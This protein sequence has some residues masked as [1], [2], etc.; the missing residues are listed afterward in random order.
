MAAEMPPCSNYGVAHVFVFGGVSMRPVSI[1]DRLRGSSI[2]GVAVGS[3]GC[4]QLDSGSH[5]NPD[6]ADDAELHARGV[7]SRS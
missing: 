2:V 4:E 7:G 3:F 1:A 6:A 5:G